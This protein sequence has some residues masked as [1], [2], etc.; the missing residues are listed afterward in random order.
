MATFIDS[1][2]SKHN[3]KRIMRSITLS[4]GRPSELD[5][6]PSA[7][8][9]TSTNSSLVTVDTDSVEPLTLRRDERSSMIARD[10][11]PSA[12]PQLLSCTKTLITQTY[13]NPHRCRSWLGK[14]AAQ[15]LFHCYSKALCL[16]EGRRP[17]HHC[18]SNTYS[19]KAAFNSDIST[20]HTWPLS[21]SVISPHVN[22]VNQLH[23]NSM[24]I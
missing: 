2:S 9:C 24:P 5:G 16:F 13:G 19:Q 17:C 12:P 1:K 21:R 14:R 4:L 6:E 18:S 7:P 20:E 23:H 11:P 22:K 3:G 8:F 10:A 15:V